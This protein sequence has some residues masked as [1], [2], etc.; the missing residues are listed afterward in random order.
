MTLILTKLLDNEKIVVH[1][2]PHVVC[3]NNSPGNDYELCY[4]LYNKIKNQRLILS[5]FFI[6]PI[7]AK[8]YISALDFFTGSRMHACI[9]AFSSGVPVYPISYSRKF[10]GLFN[11]TLNYDCVGDLETMENLNIIENLLDAIQNRE[12]L[13]EKIYKLKDSIIEL[14]YKQLMSELAKFMSLKN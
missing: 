6:D 4:F 10:I 11:E 14:K 5:P 1:L 13:K 2:V 9:A 7:K 3:E 12:I 8:N